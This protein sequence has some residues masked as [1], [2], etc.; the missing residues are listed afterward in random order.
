MHVED[1]ITRMKACKNKM[2]GMSN[3]P[4][5]MPG[6]GGEKSSAKRDAELIQKS[7]FFSKITKK[8]RKKADSIDVRDLVKKC[9]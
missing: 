2:Y 9:K 7:D 4:S 6:D 1:L 5:D 8:I 3:I